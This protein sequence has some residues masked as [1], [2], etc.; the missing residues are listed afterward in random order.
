MSQ[1]YEVILLK[2]DLAEGE[3]TWLQEHGVNSPDDD[4]LSR[5]PTLGEMSKALDE[6]DACKAWKYGGGVIDVWSKYESGSLAMYAMEPYPEKPDD[7][8][9]FYF[10]RGYFREILEPLLDQLSSVC[11][12]MAVINYALDEVVYVT[13]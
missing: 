2:S 5:W 12:P 11:G 3:R 9:A 10:H 1:I 6:L 4:R 13:S 7:E 8:L